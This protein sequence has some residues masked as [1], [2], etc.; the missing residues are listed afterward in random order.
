MIPYLMLCVYVLFLA[1]AGLLRTRGGSAWD[2]LTLNCNAQLALL[3]LGN[4]IYAIRQ[5][6]LPRRG[7]AP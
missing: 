4:I 2:E 1:L 3:A 5:M 7:G 6:I